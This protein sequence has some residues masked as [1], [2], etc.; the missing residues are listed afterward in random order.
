MAMLLSNNPKF[1][2]VLDE[3]IQSTLQP[4]IVHFRNYDATEIEQILLDR[5]LIGL[6]T[7]PTPVLS[8]IAAMTAKNTHSDVRVA[9]KTLYLWALEP[10]RPHCRAL[11]EGPARYHL[12]RDPGPQRQESPDPQGR[13]R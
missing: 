10:Q 12:R 8:E 9:I 13:A 3:S 6:K 7:T 11:R 2:H 5:A 1:L 4:E